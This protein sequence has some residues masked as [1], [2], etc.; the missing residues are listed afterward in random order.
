VE[1]TLDSRKI[2]FIAIMSS[3]G[4]LLSAASLQLA[5]ILATVSGQGGAALDLSHIAT[6]IAAIFGGPYVGAAVGFLSGIYAGYYFGYVLGSLGFISLIGVPFG[7]ALT[8]FTA[9]FLYKKLGIARRSR[10]SIL[11][12]LV[13]LVSYVPESIYTYFYFVNIAVYVVGYA[14]TFMLPIVI[15]KAW[16]EV[17]LMSL[18]M[19]ALSGNMGFRNFLGTYFQSQKSQR[20]ISEAKAKND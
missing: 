9:G 13:V 2:A 16:I 7:K 8:G 15:P 11:T 20:T 10:V 1:V 17:I 6:F 3:L 19:G 5:P 12:V 14:M 18:L 4:A